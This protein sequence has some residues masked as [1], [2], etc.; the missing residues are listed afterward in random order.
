MGLREVSADED[1]DSR[2]RGSTPS[3]T[4]DGKAAIT[5]DFV[6]TDKEVSGP[7][8]FDSTAST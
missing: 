1:D 4:S 2:E 8:R 5:G 7:R 6:L 3:L